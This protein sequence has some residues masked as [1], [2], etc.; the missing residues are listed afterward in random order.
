MRLKRNV[1]SWKLT[2]LF[3]IVLCFLLVLVVAFIFET[4]FPVSYPTSETMLVKLRIEF[5]NSTD[6]LLI[7]QKFTVEVRNIQ[8]DDLLEIVNATNGVALTRKQYWI[9]RH[10]EPNIFSVQTVESQ[11]IKIVALNRTVVEE[12]SSYYPPTE[13]ELVIVLI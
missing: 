9:T 3:V 4:S 13:T 10:I 8:T 7:D 1:E 6:G 2:E 11:R 12:V 5:R